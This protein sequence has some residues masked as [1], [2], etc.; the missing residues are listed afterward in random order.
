MS[1][2]TPLRRL[3]RLAALGRLRALP[4]GSGRE[5]AQHRQWCDEE[6][7]EVTHGV[8]FHGDSPLVFYLMGYLMA[9][10]MQ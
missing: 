1:A 3:W 5:T 4:G 8:V 6:G 7:R 9:P 10:D 2:T